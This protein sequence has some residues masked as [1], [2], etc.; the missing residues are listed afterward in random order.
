MASCPPPVSLGSFAPIAHRLV[1]SLI[2]VNGSWKHHTG[3]TQSE[4]CHAVT[5][6]Q[7]G[8]WQ[9]AIEGSIAGRKAAEIADTRI[10]WQPQ[11]RLRSAG[12]CSAVRGAPVA[13][14]GGDGSGSGS[15]PNA[16][17]STRAASARR[18]RA[19]RRFRSC[20]GTAQPGADPRTGQEC[21]DADGQSAFPRPPTRLTDTRSAHGSIAAPARAPPR[22]R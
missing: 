16:S 3:P 20:A 6:P 4:L 21:R 10:A 18:R 17:Y 7:R 14:G 12:L 9:F 15:C 22:C 13:S 1:H 11:G 2:Y 19:P 8:R 5:S